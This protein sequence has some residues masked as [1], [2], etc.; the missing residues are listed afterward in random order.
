MNQRM[1]FTT[2]INQEDA[3]IIVF[4]AATHPFLQRSK[5][6][7]R[8]YANLAFSFMLQKA[9]Y[10][11][12]SFLPLCLWHYGNKKPDDVSYLE[13]FVNYMQGVDTF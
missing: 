5:P 12:Y 3:C 4:F 2:L 10:L 8:G 1:H 11:S 7:S 9:S 6:K 13:Q